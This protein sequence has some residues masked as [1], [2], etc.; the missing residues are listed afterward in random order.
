MIGGYLANSIA[1]FTDSAHLA[2][3]IV[4]FGISIFSLKMATTPATK[5]LS[6]GY[7][8][9][10]I[11]GT[12]VSL[13]LIWGLTIWLVYEATLRIFNPAE[14]Q[15]GIMMFVSVMGLC[16]NLIQIRILHHGHHGHGHDH[17]HSHLPAKDQKITDKASKKASKDLKEG[18]INKDEEATEHATEDNEN[19][20]EEHKKEPET[21]KAMNLNIT[22]A[23]LHVLGD[24][25][26]SVGVITAAIVIN[27]WPSAKIADPLCTYFFSIIICCTTIP[28]VRECIYVLLEATPNDFD[29][30]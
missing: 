23:Y 3:D 22:S 29:Q 18:L 12:L 28:V 7:H 4:G 6:Y 20:A 13:V 27:I 26:M 21:K 5:N 2:S 24:C 17:D 10:E 11:I 1:I 19:G 16:F 8:R 9:S 25:L 14:I 15:Q 30:E